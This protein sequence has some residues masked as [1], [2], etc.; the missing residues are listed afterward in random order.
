MKK[1]TK[2]SGTNSALN[3]KVS[4][5]AIQNRPGTSTTTINRLSA[6][7]STSA[8]L[9]PRPRLDSSKVNKDLEIVAGRKPTALQVSPF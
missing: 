4:V 2:P 8:I 1:L 6:S 9:R 7:T 5:S 3:R